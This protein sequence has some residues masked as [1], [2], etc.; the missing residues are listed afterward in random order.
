ME[1]SKRHE[2]NNYYENYSDTS[3]TKQIKSSDSS[4]KT[5]TNEQLFI[6]SETSQDHFESYKE[7]IKT[8]DYDFP[9]LEAILDITTQPN[10]LREREIKN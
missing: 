4:Y 7:N 10:F 8:E 9:Y 5:K 1:N 2:K 3:S 6:K